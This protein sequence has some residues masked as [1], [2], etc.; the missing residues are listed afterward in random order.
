MEFIKQCS[1]EKIF[2][3][4]TQLTQDKILFEL[5]KPPSH[6]GDGVVYCLNESVLLTRK[7][8]LNLK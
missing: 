3:M 1:L 8:N 2:N 4:N 7:L 6:V 5:T